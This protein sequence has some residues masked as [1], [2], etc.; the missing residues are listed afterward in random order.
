MR[1]SFSEF[2]H[3]RRPSF[4]LFSFTK[5]TIAAKTHT[6]AEIDFETFQ[7]LVVPNCKKIV[8]EVYDETSDIV[9]ATISNPGAVFGRF[10]PLFSKNSF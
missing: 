5:W 7:E 1:A 2:A 6:E 4:S 8:P 9:V 10:V 3:F